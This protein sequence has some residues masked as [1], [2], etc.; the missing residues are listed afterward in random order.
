MVLSE[1]ACP[2]RELRLQCTAVGGFAT[3]WRGTAFDCLGLGNEIL[4]RHSQ[5]ELGRATGVCNS[6]MIT[7][8]NL[9]RTFDGPNSTF[10]SQLKIHLPLLNAASNTLEG[11]T[12]ECTRDSETVIGNHTIAYTRFS[13]GRS[14]YFIMN[15]S[16]QITTQNFNMQ[17]H[18]LIMFTS[19]KSLRMH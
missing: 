1:C 13:S 5:F 16:I 2:G 15:I 10:I 4:L 12:V 9:N 17:L 11:E 18:L 19:P 8:R 3:V 6:G 7:G 14:I